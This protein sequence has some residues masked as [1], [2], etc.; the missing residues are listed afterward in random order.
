VRHGQFVKHDPALRWYNRVSLVYALGAAAF[1]A[2][3][4][5]AL[6]IY[7]LSR[8]HLLLAG[9][10]ILLAIC[11]LLFVL[12]AGTVAYAVQLH[13]GYDPGAA[14]YQQ[15]MTGKAPD[16]LTP[17]R[18]RIFGIMSLAVAYAGGHYLLKRNP[19]WDVDLQLPDVQIPP[20]IENLWHAAW[21]GLRQLLGW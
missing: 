17:G 4:V 18:A 6:L 5:D 15:T 7:D 14:A 8:W 11:G 3:L 10:L 9:G 16:T 20:A 21:G 19:R 12:R 13:E 2:T 1:V